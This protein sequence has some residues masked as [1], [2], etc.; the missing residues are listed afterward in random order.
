VVVAVADLVEAVEGVGRMK[1]I[2]RLWR[3]LMAGLLILITL[4]IILFQIFGRLDHRLPWL[5]ALLI[6]YIVSSYLILPLL[7]RVNLLISRKGRIPRFTTALEGSYVDPVNIILIGTK[8]QLI[9]AFEKIEW[10]KA[11]KLNIKTSGEMIEK[12]LR[13]RPY[14]QAPFSFHFLFGRRQ[15]IGFQQ[16]VGNSPRRRHHV[17]FWG[18]DVDKIVDP[19]DIKFWTEKKKIN[20][21]ESL[22]WIGAGSEDI[23]FG[24]S[25]L[26]FKISH[27]INYKIDNER[28]Y[29]LNLLKSKKLIS[30]VTYYKSGEF[31][32]GK[33]VSDGR[34]AVAKLTD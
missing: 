32:V 6:T 2:I 17:R 25:R 4:W 22:S 13:N 21:N 5:I 28:K 27:R 26:T 7:V 24:F 16:P 1:K 15:D 33:Y 23:G 14:L 12:F 19:L 10:F 8:K 30:K 20:F 9:K 11:D 31:K 29:I 34:I 3:D 18:V